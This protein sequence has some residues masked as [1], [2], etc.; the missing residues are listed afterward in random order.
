MLTKEIN[1]NKKFI[2]VLI[3]INVIALGLYY[4]YALFILYGASNGGRKESDGNK[5][6]NHWSHGVG[7]EF[8][9][10][11]HVCYPPGDQGWNGM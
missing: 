8:S 2:L 4:S 9:K 10:E 11:D 7:S 6:R 5:D 1:L 3:L